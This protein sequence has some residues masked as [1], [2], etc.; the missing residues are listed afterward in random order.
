MSEIELTCN[1]GYVNLFWETSAEI[2]NDYFMIEASENGQLFNEIGGVEGNGTTVE[3][4]AYS[5]GYENG[6]KGYSYFRITQVD[7]NGTYDISKTVYN[8]C[9][10]KELNFSFYPNPSS[11]RLTIQYPDFG[12][13]DARL[14]ITDGLGAMV[15][16]IVLN[17]T[18]SNSIS[19]LN[20]SELLEGFYLLTLETNVGRNSKKLIIKR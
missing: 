12:H 18:Y 11:Q 19:K 1:D 5:F 20:V 9:I 14:I 17:D 2:N 6:G 16:V 8:K 7:F 10:Q 4:T 15:R 3:T 13:D